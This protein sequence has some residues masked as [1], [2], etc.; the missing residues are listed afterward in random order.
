MWQELREELHPRGLE[1][2]TVALDLKGVETAGRWIEAAAPRHPALID[3]AH[4]VDELLGIVNVPS[5][6]WIDE[7]GAIVRPAEPAV[8]R[9]APTRRVPFAAPPTRVP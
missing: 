3:R 5:G 2:V 1:V 8:P 6:V 4:V 9:R 7:G